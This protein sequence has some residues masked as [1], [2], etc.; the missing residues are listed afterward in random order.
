LGIPGGQQ[1]ASPPTGGEA[2]TNYDG[3]QCVTFVYG[4]HSFGS[5][6]GNRLLH[7]S[8]LAFAMTVVIG[9]GEGREK[10]AGHLTLIKE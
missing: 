5:K 7:A 6:E 3:V 4:L 1:I 10:E 2:M 9:A 8:Y